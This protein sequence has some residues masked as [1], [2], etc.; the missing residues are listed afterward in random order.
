MTP[1]SVSDAHLF[2]RRVEQ[3]APKTG[4]GCIDDTDVLLVCSTLE[5]VGGITA[6]VDT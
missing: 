6:G 1:K 4:V 2:S 3:G 5:G